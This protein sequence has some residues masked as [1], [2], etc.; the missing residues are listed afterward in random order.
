MV[1]HR[2]RKHL[3]LHESTQRRLCR[4]SLFLFAILP[5]CSCFVFVAVSKTGW[6]QLREAAYWR[7]RIRNNLGMDI[8]FSRIEFPAPN[9]FRIRELVCADPE[10]KAPILYASQ[11]DGW[12][13]SSGWSIQIEEAEI[14]G[15][16]SELAIRLVHDSFLCRPHNLVPLLKLSLRRAILQ[17]DEPIAAEESRS[18]GH[19]QEFHQVEVE[20]E[21]SL[22]RSQLK[23]QFSLAQ[24]TRSAPALLHISRDHSSENPT[25]HWA[26]RTGF[27]RIPCRFFSSCFPAVTSCGANAWFQGEAYWWQDNRNFGCEIRD[28]RVEQIDLGIATHTFGSPIQGKGQLQIARSTWM[29]GQLLTATGAMGGISQ[30][31]GDCLRESIKRFGWVSNPLDDLSD[32]F[33]IVDECGIAFDI[34]SGGIVLSGTGKP[35][36]YDGQKYSLGL[37]A[38]GKQCFSR[39][40]GSVL[41]IPLVHE[42]LGAIQQGLSRERVIE[43]QTSLVRM[44]P[45]SLPR[46][47]V[48]LTGNQKTIR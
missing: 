19:D 30:I 8:V 15:T 11:L 6:Y 27:C 1:F 5:L 23:V 21:P 47:D 31:K 24:N 25:T 48:H 3:W 43:N 32:G 13:S 44:L 42:W 38:Q 33:A 26:L 45:N 34:S 9:R 41:S 28:G 10:T 29:N 20:Y 35:Y 14:R 40:S 39:G 12:M 22:V 37:V 36:P 7:E 46:Q 4:F 2:R 18:T 16:Q 17:S